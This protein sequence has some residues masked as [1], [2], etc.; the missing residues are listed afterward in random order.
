MAAPGFRDEVAKA[1]CTLPCLLSAGCVVLM[2]GAH[3]GASLKGGIVGNAGCLVAAVVL[4]LASS[5]GGMAGGSRGY[6]GID[7]RS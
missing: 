5:R 3:D 4:L 6:R 7:T 2:G 1:E